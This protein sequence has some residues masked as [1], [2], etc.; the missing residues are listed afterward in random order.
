LVTGEIAVSTHTDVDQVEALH[1]V[2]S[3]TGRGQVVG[4]FPMDAA[5]PSSWSPDGS[6]LV[7]AD[8]DGTVRMFNRASGK[9]VPVKPRLDGKEVGIWKLAWSTDGQ[10]LVGTA[11]NPSTEGFALVSMD[12]DG[13]SVEVLTPWSM[14]LYSSA[15]LSWG[16]P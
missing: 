2:D 8:S 12:P 9:A 5:T 15:D 16:P 3:D 1:I 4:T 7:F 6:R 11:A 14:A 10:R 13:S